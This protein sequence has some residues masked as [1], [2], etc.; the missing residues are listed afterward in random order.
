MILSSSVFRE[1]ILKAPELGKS[2]VLSRA[3]SLVITT[4]EPPAV[5]YTHLTLPTN[6][7]V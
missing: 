2:V 5:S 4:V 7:E 1:E 3:I 6:R